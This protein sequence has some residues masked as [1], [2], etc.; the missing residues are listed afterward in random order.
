LII[1]LGFNS[2][3]QNQNVG[4]GTV[5]PDASAIL[6]ISSTNKGLLAPRLTT[7]QRQAIASPAIG[8]LVY[9]ITI[10][11]YFYFNN[12]WVSLCQLSGPQG[13][14]GQQGTTGTNG[15]NG[16]TGLTGA[17]G[18]QGITGAI[19]ATGI[20]GTTGA[21]GTQGVTGATGL[22]G[23]SGNTGAT[24]FLP[25]G[26][27]IG[28]TPYWD[29][30]QWVVNSLNIDNAG[31]HVVIWNTLGLYTT[32]TTAQLNFNGAAGD[33][34]SFFGSAPNIYGFGMQTAELQMYTAYNNDD[35][36]F[37]YGASA[38]FTENVRFK[39]T[40]NVGIGT[41]TPNYKLDVNGTVAGVNAYVQTSDARYKKNIQPI[42][43]G[44][45]LVAKMKPVS[46]E[47]NK[48]AY[49][50]KNFENKPQLGFIAQDMEKIVPQA[51][52]KD[53][54]GYYGMSY[55]TLIPVLV[56]AIQEQQEIITKQ[57]GRI[58]KLEKELTNFTHSS[59]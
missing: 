38:N 34:I 9:D 53:S 2:S 58:E 42:T 25:N 36:V 8:L 33:M 7:S 54:S 21:T 27:S 31:G 24:G 40:R 49:P 46:Y 5:T 29:G 56:K 59:K 19:G 30:T 13:A 32:N 16:T 4:I 18:S 55:T 14:T 11:C 6:D 47:W 37:G 35:I 48:E 23:M 52:S 20:N 3:A 51:V 41:S 15:N 44:L 45:S 57:N 10:G 22:T 1:F 17:T 12:T 43:E 50:K 39:G 28:D 26:Q